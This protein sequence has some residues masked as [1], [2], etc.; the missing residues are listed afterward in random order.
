MWT[1]KQPQII[2]IMCSSENDTFS[3][4]T[5]R[6]VFEQ[7]ASTNCSFGQKHSGSET[8]KVT[9]NKYI[10]LSQ[11]A[12]EAYFI[13]YNKQLI[14]LCMTTIPTLNYDHPE[15]LAS[16]AMGLWGICPSSISHCLIFH[17][18]RHSTLCGFP[19]SKKTTV[20]YSGIS[21]AQLLYD[22]ELLYI[23]FLC[24]P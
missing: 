18:L 14:T 15:S 13:P 10:T 16:P 11:Y 7:Q 6:A 2:N 1:L 3:N 22:T 19:A 20:V 24:H 8:P 5:H 12:T 23:L 9:L 4:I 21:A 17:K